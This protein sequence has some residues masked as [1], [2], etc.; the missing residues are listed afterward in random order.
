MSMA[1][2][3]VCS[4]H[5]PVFFIVS[6]LLK[7]HLYKE[8]EAYGNISF[9]E[10][11]KK[12]AVSLL[13]PFAI[14]S[15]FNSTLKL[16]VL[17][18]THS[19]T[20][21]CIQEEMLDLFI[22]GNGTVWFLQ[23]LFISELLFWWL[24]RFSKKWLIC[25]A[26]F[27]IAYGL[28]PININPLGIVLIRVIVSTAYIMLG[29]IILP[30][31][32]KISKISI[33]IGLSVICFLINLL[34]VFFVNYNYIYFNGELGEIEKTLLPTIVGSFGIIFICKALEIYDA[35]NKLRFSRYLGEKSLGI[36]LVH[37]TVLLV[38]TYLFNEKIFE[39]VMGI[40][41]V[42]VSLGLFLAVTAITLIAIVPIYKFLPWVF[43]I[44]K[45][46]NN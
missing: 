46:K 37:P 21:S 29:F 35:K 32:N 15:L 40:S 26:L 19:L 42:F 25:I 7:G 43:G 1:N 18:L 10:L 14:F 6:G 27:L 4:F 8:S 9:K 39:K 5:V 16:G 17:F 36:M 45:E 38:F 30:F 28:T 2:K 22:K 24:A 11:V 41:A 12:R 23:T 13:I 3:F 33:N 44:K 34:F 31:V 20:V